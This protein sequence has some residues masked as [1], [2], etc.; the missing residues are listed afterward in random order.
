[1]DPL[2]LLTVAGIS[3]CSLG[4]LWQ[5]WVLI[6]R[7]GSR[8]RRLRAW[9]AIA[10]GAGPILG[11]TPGMAGFHG[12]AL[13]IPA[14]AAVACFALFLRLSNMAN[15]AAADERRNRDP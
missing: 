7:P 4:V 13:T 8:Q 6:L 12:W 10:A 3:G 5:A 15:A 9:A 14:L 1:M 2:S 11:V